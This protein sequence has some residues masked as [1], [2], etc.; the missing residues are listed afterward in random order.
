MAVDGSAAEDLELGQDLRVAGHHLGIAHHLGQ[1]EN[2]RLL[3]EFI[4]EKRPWTLLEEA[5][6][7]PSVFYVGGKPPT[8]KMREIERPEVRV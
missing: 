5:G 6:T 1:T 2:A 7:D 4:R 3:H 8:T